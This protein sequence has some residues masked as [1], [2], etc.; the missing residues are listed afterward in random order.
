MKRGID[1]RRWVWQWLSALALIPLALW[2][3]AM[4]FAHRGAGRGE[5]LAWLANPVAALPMALLLAA[6]LFHMNLGL[7]VVIEDYVH[8]AACERAALRAAN[9]AAWL[10]ALIGLTALAK[11]AFGG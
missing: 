9:L 3:V 8:G 6:M 1:T 7:R 5:I 11:L 2:F 10:L 4:I